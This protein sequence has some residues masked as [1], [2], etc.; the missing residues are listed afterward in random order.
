MLANSPQTNDVGRMS[1]AISD[2]SHRPLGSPCA[3]EIHESRVFGP[4]S[5]PP[6]PAEVELVS[7]RNVPTR[8]LPRLIGRKYHRLGMWAAVCCML[9]ARLAVR[10]W[11]AGSCAHWAE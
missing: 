8:T 9:A 4:A 10:A 5:G 1:P 7:P 11:Q 3:A 2:S 6:A